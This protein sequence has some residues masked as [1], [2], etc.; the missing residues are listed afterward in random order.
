MAEDPTTSA[1]GE[2]RGWPVADEDVTDYGDGRADDRD[3]PA[4]Q[5]DVEQ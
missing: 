2:D 1:G 3:Q 4:G 5:S